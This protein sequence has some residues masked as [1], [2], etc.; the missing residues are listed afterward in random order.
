MPW[1]NQIMGTFVAMSLSYASSLKNKVEA[2]GRDDGGNFGFASFQLTSQAVK[3]L[4]LANNFAVSMTM[5]HS[6]SVEDL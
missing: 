5:S 1:Y 4:L 3:L 2:A 6:F